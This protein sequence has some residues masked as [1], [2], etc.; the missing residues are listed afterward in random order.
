MAAR[1]RYARAALM[2][3][4]GMLPTTTFIDTPKLRLHVRDWGGPAHHRPALVFIHGLASNARIWDLT[5]PALASDFRLV[6]LDQRGHGLSAKPAEGYDFATITGDLAAA[7]AA[8]GLHQ[9]LLVGHS[10]GANV[11]LQL[12]ADQ[13]ALL[14]GIV[15]VDGV[16]SNMADM[17]TLEETLEQLAPPRLAGTPRPVFQENLR[18]RWLGELWSP[19]VEE[20]VMGNFSVDAEDRIAPH[21]SFDR[22]LKILRAMWDQRPGQIFARVGVPTLII[23]AEPPPP[24]D[25][26]AVAWLERKRQAVAHASATIPQARVV[27]ANNSVHDVPLH[28]PAFLA[29]QI[30]AFAQ[31]LGAAG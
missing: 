17:M 22:H 8:L 3:E 2:K 30:A 18:S 29:Q 9:P 26:Q 14:C 11:A 28:H 23:P 19:Q 12:A 16:L 20:I 25:E 7:I 5:A 6:A 10:W 4:H 1:G 24:L 27:W 15:L 31:E 21:L 13:P